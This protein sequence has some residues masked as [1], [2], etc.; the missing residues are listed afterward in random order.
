M[1][2]PIEVFT[3]IAK[4]IHPLDLILLSRANKFFRQLLLNRSAIQTWRYAL[5]N[6]DGLPPCPEGLCEPQYAALIFSKYCSMCGKQ[7]PRPMDPVL[8]VRLCGACRDQQ[9]VFAAS[10]Y[11]ITDMASPASSVCKVGNREGL[12]PMSRTTLPAKGFVGCLRKDMVALEDKLNALRLAGDETARLYWVDQRRQE[13][14]QRVQDARPLADFLRQQ[15][16]DQSDSLA[17][18]RGQREDAIRS[19]L[20]ELGWVEEDFEMRDKDGVKEWKSLVCIAK[21]LTER[22]WETILP[23]LTLLLERNREL[24][25]E[26]EASERRQ[27]R[28]IRT[29]QWI[30]SAVQEL[31]P[32]ARVLD[33]PRLENEEIATSSNSSRVQELSGSSTDTSE[34]SKRK[35]RVLKAPFPSSGAVLNWEPFEQLM[36]ADVPMESFE[37]ALAEMHPTLNRLVVEWRVDL[38][39]AL[40]QRLPDDNHLAAPVSNGEAGTKSDLI[41]KLIV[42]VDSQPVDKLPLDTQRLLRADVIWNSTSN[43]PW[44][45]TDDFQDIYSGAGNSISFHTQASEIA[46]E[47]L[48]VLGHPNAT[49]LQMKG[50]GSVF[51]CGRCCA[52]Q[53]VT[54]DNMVRLLA[55]RSEQC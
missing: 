27:Y 20:L 17:A 11:A 10:T 12:V 15:E 1:N 25:L 54:W 47:L 35:N 45:Y 19:R 26:V 42:E 18:R 21:P 9:Y 5:S 3:E 24:R 22:N 14:R 6:V 30:S 34:D 40:V 55:T 44:F 39:K 49:Y 16:T 46:K 32:Y 7:A 53:N 28:Y 41:S 4:Y 23:Q 50:V 43:T 8:R 52:C 29:S 48:A 38:E 2:M 37:V 36:G 31:R 33:C 51:T 13:V